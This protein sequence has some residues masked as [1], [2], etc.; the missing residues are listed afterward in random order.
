[1][2]KILVTL[3]IFTIFLTGCSSEG[4]NSKLENQQRMVQATT[5]RALKNYKIDANTR[6]RKS[7]V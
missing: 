6:D 1:M 4:S 2:K 3:I 5:Q 7:V